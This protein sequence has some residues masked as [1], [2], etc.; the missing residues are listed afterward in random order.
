MGIDVRRHDTARDFL[1]A[2]GATLRRRPV[3][4]Q[5]PIAIAD[6]C[7]IDPDAYGGQVRL[8][9]AW[10]DGANAGAALQ[11][12]P[13][14]VQLAESEPD[15]A[16]A[17]GAAFA[18]HHAPIPAVA[19]PDP[20]PEHFAAA[21]AAACG[22]TYARDIGLGTFELERVADLPAMPGR[23]VVAGGEHVALVQAWLRAFHDEATP[24]DPPTAD[25]A[26]ARAVTGARAHLWLDERDRPVAIAFTNRE[27]ENWTSIGPVY[28]P[29]E[30]RGRGYA[31]AVVAALS[32]HLL[33]LG[34]TGC[35]LFTNLANP[36]SNAIYERI[37]Y[38]R[39]GTST[40][41]GFGAGR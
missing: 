33:D 26:A 2:C 35:T 19:G 12:L 15:A 27:V 22:A 20:A 39:V 24:H 13:W 25:T 18:Q 11:T 10:R 29:P 5:L 36:I 16:A 30:L 28:T 23:R 7:A 41:Y 31:T 4:N 37:G 34:R 40:R 32:R 3:A 6:R 1:D 17:L 21:Y 8:W 14:P 9:T 38:R